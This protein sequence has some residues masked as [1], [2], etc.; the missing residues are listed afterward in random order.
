MHKECC[1]LLIKCVC[2]LLAVCPPRPLPGSSSSLPR[3]SVLRVDHF[4]LLMSWKFCSSIDLFLARNPTGSSMFL[5]R[6][7]QPAYWRVHGMSP[8]NGWAD[9][10]FTSPRGV[11][12]E[13]G[14]YA[15]S[16]ALSSFWRSVGRGTAPTRVSTLS[17]S[18]WDF[19]ESRARLLS[20]WVHFTQTTLLLD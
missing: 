16:G 19:P 6:W 5:P 18:R 3:T 11:Y 17:P 2:W 20:T 13:E 12:S 10:T 1:H 8:N 14:D 9:V 15:I 7:R 4:P